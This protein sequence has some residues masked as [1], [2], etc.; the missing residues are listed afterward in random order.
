M[1]LIT[2]IGFLFFAWTIFGQQ[3]AQFT[4]YYSNPYLFNPASGGLKKIIDIDLGYRRQWIGLSGAP[5]SFYATAH[6]EISFDKRNTVLNEHN[7]EDESIYATPTNSVGKN[8]HVVGGKVFADQIGPFQKI[9][10][11]ASYA[12]H[13]RFTQKTML[14]FGVNAGYSNF[15]INPNKVILL[16][17]DDYKYENFLSRNSNQSIFDLG[18]GMTFY[19]KEFQFGIS[20]SQLLNNN[21]KLGEVETSAHFS[22]HFFLYGMYNFNLE[23]TKLS[24]EPHFMTQFASG[25]PASVNIGA[26]LHYDKRYWVNVS[27]RLQDAIAFGVGLNF[28]KNLHLGYSYDVAIGKVQRPNNYVHEISLGLMFGSKSSKEKDLQDD[29]MM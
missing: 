9:N 24:V 28:A 10:V 29:E 2:I 11:M 22:S 15:G 19:G 8:K 17:N 13:L 14:S 1:K 21:L 18:A 16:D 4:Q 12:Y 20:S 6:T 5:Q 3:E 26:R 27:Y 23:D 7:S 25:A